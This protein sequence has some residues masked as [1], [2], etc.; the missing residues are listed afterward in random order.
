MTKTRET[1]GARAAAAAPRVKHRKPAAERCEELVKV[2]VT[3]DER[4]AIE[5]AAAKA[6][7][8]VSAWARLTLVRAAAEDAEP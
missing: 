4:A 5:A 8:T 3:K 2:L 1:K 6:Q 7:R